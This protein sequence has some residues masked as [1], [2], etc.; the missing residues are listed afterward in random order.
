MTRVA[1][2]CGHAELCTGICT[3]QLDAEDPGEFSESPS[4]DPIPSYV[5]AIYSVAAE[6]AA[7]PDPEPDATFGCMWEQRA[8]AVGCMRLGCMCPRC[9]SR[10]AGSRSEVAARS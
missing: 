2:G 5:V 9:R 4:D 6:P 10:L 1:T 8:A 7:A 3:D